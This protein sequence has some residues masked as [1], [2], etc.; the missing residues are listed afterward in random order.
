MHA[1]THTHTLLLS[2][3]F[4]GSGCLSGDQAQMS[5][6][7]QG[8]RELASQSPQGSLLKTGGEEGWKRPAKDELASPGKASL[9]LTHQY[10]GGRAAR[11]HHG[12]LGSR[13]DIW[14]GGDALSKG[15]IQGPSIKTQLSQ[16]GE[17]LKKQQQTIKALTQ[18]FLNCGFLAVRPGRPPQRAA[19]RGA[20]F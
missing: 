14:P 16:E 15:H 3:A 4:Q 8:W 19:S 18:G 1:R 6:H 10:D 17:G 12:A 13:L 2:S 7:Q 5:P 9:N 20:V 11:Q